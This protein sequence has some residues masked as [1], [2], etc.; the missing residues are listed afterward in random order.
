[1]TVTAAVTVRPCIQ[2]LTAIAAVLTLLSAPCASAATSDDRVA[3]TV[4]VRPGDSLSVLAARNGV[5]IEDLRRWNPKKIGKT[6][7]IRAG[8]TLVVMVPKGSPEAAAA[9]GPAWTGY[10]DI[11]S[12]DT[13]S[14]V[15]AALGVSM[16]ELRQWNKLGKDGV[17]RAGRTLRYV[18]HGPR[19]PSRSV[20]TTTHG[21]VEQPVRLGEGPGY[22]L[23]FPRNTYTLP[24]VVTTL[25][26]C[27]AR[28]KRRFK[29]TADIL[30]GDLSR[31]TG[32]RFPP[33]VSHQSGRDADVGY[34]IV[35]NVQNQTMYRLK[36][37]E[38]DYEKTWELLLCF[39]A[40]DEVVR[41]FMD[42][43]FQ[44]RMAQYLETSKRLD[45]K[46]IDRLF[47]AVGDIHDDALVQHAPAHDTH[48]HVRFA[49]EPDDR[50][51]AEDPGERPF[52]L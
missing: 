34:Y 46:R 27:T 43:S 40:E 11:K 50:E 32:G 21:R 41:V 24:S 20:G 15:A 49:C 33:H 48:L 52:H 44:K 17:I 3:A 30:I 47:A 9:A 1:M 28:M 14:K 23:R 16:A 2:S 29:G 51:C 6:D 37:H 22:R 25:Q 19:P 10:Y 42:T 12:G 26:R 31:A 13:L 18:K 45:A 39:L 38:V 7:L 35:G 36:A 8:D 4:E 5:S